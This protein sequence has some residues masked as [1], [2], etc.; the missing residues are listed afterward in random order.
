[1]F[2]QHQMPMAIFSNCINQYLPEMQSTEQWTRNF[3]FLKLTNK[4]PTLLIFF[5]DGLL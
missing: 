1:M 3:I 5:L 2:S 4:Q